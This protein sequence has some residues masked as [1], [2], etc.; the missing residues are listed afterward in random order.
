MLD[1][2]GK[3]A[4]LELVIYIPVSIFCIFNNFQ[5]GFRREAGWIYLT[6]FCAGMTPSPLIYILMYIRMR[7]T[8]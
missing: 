6:L 8:C 2:H 4:V 3:I 7:L 5:H 1:S